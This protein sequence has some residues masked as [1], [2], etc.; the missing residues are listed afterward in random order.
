MLFNDRIHAVVALVFM[1]VVVMV[2]IASITLWTLILS[3]RRPA[4]MTETP[5]VAREIEQKSH[6]ET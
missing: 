3:R 6:A 1:G 5:F 4:V 2:L